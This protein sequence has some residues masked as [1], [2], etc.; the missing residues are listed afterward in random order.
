MILRKYIRELMDL[1]AKTRGK[2]QG[3]QKLANEK[4]VKTRIISSRFHQIS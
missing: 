2:L 1:C 3:C 4:V